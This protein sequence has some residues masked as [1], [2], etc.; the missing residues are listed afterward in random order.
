MI[1]VANGCRGKTR[2]VHR[3]K[4]LMAGKKILVLGLARSG[5]AAVRLLREAGAEVVAA[6]ENPAVSAPDVTGGLPVEIGPFDPCLLDGCDEVIVSPGVPVDHPFLTEAAQRG[7]PV[8]SEL[9]LGWRFVRGRVIAVTGTNGK[10]TTV[11]MIGEILRESGSPV[12]VAGNV[13]LPLSGVARDLGPEG[14]YVLEVSSFQLETVK[15][16]HP[17]VAGL[18]NLTP[19]HLD[20]YASVE[21]YYRAKS[22]I[23]ENC[24]REDTLFYNAEDHRCAAIAETFTGAS[25]PFS[26]RR[27][28]DGGVYLDGDRIVR[29]RDGE[30]ERVMLRSE[31]GTVGLHN[32]ENALAAVAALSS[33]AIPAEAC[34]SALAGFRGLPHRMEEVAVVGGVFFFND[35]KATNVEATVMSLAGLDG[36]VVLIAGGHDK[37]GDFTKLLPVL[38][39]VRAVVVIGE[40]APLIEGALAAHVR[41]E[42]ARSMEEAVETAY[43]LA[44]PGQLV[45]LSPACASFDMFD[46]F[47]RRGEIFGECVRR[48]KERTG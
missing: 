28:V 38:G 18:L 47:E 16:F 10:S 26:S 6:D 4:G 42:R 27:P 5:A 24:G 36:K 30:L 40:A 31:L 3:V 22:R 19:D 9:E 15:D 34:R 48:L 14:F 33:F 17:A 8:V 12:I 35:S 25:V 46:N 45:V 32:V 20:R 44:R 23:V 37:G 1:Y 13:G 7:V 2:K 43:A 11:S 41:V 39:N 29:P 21:D